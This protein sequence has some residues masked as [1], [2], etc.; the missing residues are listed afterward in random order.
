MP[1][2]CGIYR[3][4]PGYANADSVNLSI[5]PKRSDSLQ[6]WCGPRSLGPARQ[7]AIHLG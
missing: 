5:E 7:K 3:R 6:D 2:L 1:A 4:R